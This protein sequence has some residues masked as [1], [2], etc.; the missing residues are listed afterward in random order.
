MAL[1]ENSLPESVDTLVVGGSL[2]GLLAAAFEAREGKKVLLLEA[3]PNLGGRWSPEL[4]GG[5]QLGAGLCFAHKE[6]TEQICKHIGIDCEFIDI[7]N[8][9]CLL[10]SKRGWKKVDS[11]PSWEA[12][13]SRPIEIMPKGGI[14]GI[15][16]KIVDTGTFHI[17]KEHPVVE[18][19]VEGEKAKYAQA[20]DKKIAF[21]ECI[22]ACGETVLMD[23]LSGEEIPEKGS[24]R[25]LWMK[26]FITN[27]PC[28]GIVL[29]FAHDKLIGE[30]T[31]TLA[32]P[33][34][35]SSPDMD[36]I[37]GSFIS[38]RDPSLA[39]AGKQL[40]SW[41]LSLGGQKFLLE[42][43]NNHEIMKRINLSKRVLERYLPGFKNS[44][45]F[46][47][48]QILD[49]VAELIEKKKIN[50]GRIFSNLWSVADWS[51]PIGGNFEGIVSQV[52]ERGSSFNELFS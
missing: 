35:E 16:A 29:E 30:F 46:H 1:V 37:I 5:F 24:P 27:N 47:R 26:Q 12:Y 15:I 28:S 25:T 13:F 34:S 50:K 32:F 22:W 31:E 2:G 43:D 9:D 14:A 23:V 49:H 10:A 48:V 36:H 20:G 51:S 4:R 44:I 7:K 8:G 40:S 6:A 52:L 33:L 42:K 18:L 41:V 3:S 45:L 19:Y 11:F 17:C 39:P 38:N 21:Q